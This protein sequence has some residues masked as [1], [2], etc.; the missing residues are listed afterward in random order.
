MCIYCPIPTG[1]GT[2][3]VVIIAAFAIFGHVTLL[4]A[5]LLQQLPAAAAGG[6]GGSSGRAPGK[7]QARTH[8]RWPLT[9][10]ADSGC[11]AVASGT[12]GSGGHAH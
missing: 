4:V 1:S 8:H 6:G 7:R 3:A 12:G 10:G 9:G 5:Q 2:A 11:S